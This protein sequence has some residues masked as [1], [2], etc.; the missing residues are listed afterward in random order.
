M[1]AAIDVGERNTTENRIGKQT[2]HLQYQRNGLHIH[3]YTVY[4]IHT[5][6]HIDKIAA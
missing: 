1:A 3:M 2:D 5:L 6:Y 4:T